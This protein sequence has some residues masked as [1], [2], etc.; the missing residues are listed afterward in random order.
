MGSVVPVKDSR[1]IV[2][3]RAMVA[4]K[5][6][7]PVNT[8]FDNS[9]DA[10]DWIRK[11][12]RE[13][14]LIDEGMAPPELPLRKH[15]TLNTLGKLIE[16]YLK[17]KTPEKG[18][19]VSETCTLNKFLKHDI[20][21]QYLPISL[22]DA[23]T[24]KNMRLKETWRG[25]PITSRTLRREF[26]ILQRIFVVAK[27]EWGLTTLENPF[28]EVEIKGSAHKRRRR[29]KPGEYDAL[30]EACKGCASP[31][32]QRFIPLSIFLAVE[33]AMRLDEIFNLR[34]NEIDVVKRT[35][36]IT[37]SKT[38]H[39]S[40]SAGRTI[41]MSPLATIWLRG[42][43]RFLG[44][45][46]KRTL[47]FP[48]KKAAFQQTWQSLVERASKIV[49]SITDHNADHSKEVLEFRD[50]RREAGSRFDAAGLTKA[51]HNL[52]MGH[53]SNKIEDVYIQTDLNRI[54]DK[55]DR[56]AL[57]G[58]LLTDI[59]SISF[60]GTTH[61]PNASD[62]E[63]EDRM[64]KGYTRRELTQLGCPDYQINRILS[65]LSGEDRWRFLGKWP[66]NAPVG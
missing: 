1:G 37:K 23:Y 18:S 48:M 60:G 57:D 34:W 58:K 2:K 3:Y 55:L 7:R 59:E 49:P 24:Y 64:W 41:V 30:M 43:Y 11:K 4:R 29:L 13:F 61:Y 31:L 39:V 20:C 27:K 16:K 32:N 28:A 65:K 6:H 38:D 51:E 40:A 42:F 17:E 47:V 66:R 14:K 26:N 19:H 33:T 44:D 9:D 45:D 52:M 5:G 8:R 53:N 56:H 63:N 62:E 25:K 15:P 21:K 10:W 46:D 54:R 35:I 12:E 36:T 50:L 22:Q